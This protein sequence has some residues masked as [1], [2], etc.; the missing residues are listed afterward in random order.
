MAGQSF[1]SAN[2]TAVKFGGVV[3]G[4]FSVTVTNNALG[5]VPGVIGETEP[6]ASQQI[7]AAGLRAE[8]RRGTQA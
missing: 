3:A 6:T 5:T 1:T 2:Q 4:G 7:K 8:I